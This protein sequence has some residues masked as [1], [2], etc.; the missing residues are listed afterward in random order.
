[1]D[2]AVEY[3]GGAVKDLGALDRPVAQRIVR[4]IRQKLTTAPLEYGSR[5]KYY[6]GLYKLRIGDYRVIFK[7]DND[8]CRVFIAVI[9]NR[10]EIYRILRRR[11]A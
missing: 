5:L 9:G 1:M 7:V 11:L 3:G 10:K 4:T 2:Y 6:E 8:S